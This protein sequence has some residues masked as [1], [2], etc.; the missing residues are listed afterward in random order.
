VIIQRTPDSELLSSRRLAVFV[1]GG[2]LLVVAGTSDGSWA[3]I[4]VLLGLVLV[5]VNGSLLLRRR[6]SHR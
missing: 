5:V 4:V 1:V 3:N 6:P 2:V